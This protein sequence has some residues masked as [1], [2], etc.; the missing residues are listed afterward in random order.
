MEVTFEG[1]EMTPEELRTA[2]WITKVRKHVN[3]LRD[4]ARDQRALYHCTPGLRKLGEY[5]EA[6]RKQ[7]RA[8]LLRQNLADPRALYRCAVELRELG[9]YEETTRMQ[10]RA[11]DLGL[12]QVQARVLYHCALRL[13]HLDPRVF[14]RCA[15]GLS[16]IGEYE[17]AGCKQGRALSLK[18]HLELVVNEFLLLEHDD[19]IK[20][21]RNQNM[22]R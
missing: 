7:R 21:T 19:I 16:E 18:R 22:Q 12:D 1:T 20:L 13:P 3:D 2:D 10:R 9:E 5:E 8:F 6:A 15:V 4:S 11:F 14:Y 17:K